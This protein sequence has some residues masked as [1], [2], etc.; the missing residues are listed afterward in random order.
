MLYSEAFLPFAFLLSCLLSS[1]LSSAV[2]VGI[3]LCFFSPPKFIGQTGTV[4]RIT[5][6]GDVRVQFNSETRWTFHPGALTKVRT[7]R[8]AWPELNTAGNSCQL[9]LLC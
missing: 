1:L 4:H 9:V 3:S 6:R 8:G 5:D 2:Y 7:A